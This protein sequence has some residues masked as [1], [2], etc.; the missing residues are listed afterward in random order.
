MNRVIIAHISARVVAPFGSSVVL[1]V[2]TIIP[3][4]TAHFMASVLLSDT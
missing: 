4:S 3:V 2:P 1:D